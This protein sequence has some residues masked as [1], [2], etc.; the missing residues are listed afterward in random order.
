[1]I[2]SVTTT[3][4]VSSSA[5][6]TLQGRWEEQISHWSTSGLSKA[7]YCKSTGVDYHQMIYWSRK[8]TNKNGAQAKKRDTPSA[9]SKSGGF[10]AVSVT[11]VAAEL[12]IRLPNGIEIGGI[13]EQRLIQVI[14]LVSR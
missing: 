10:V 2:D 8:L 9:S 5:P 7:A 12:F 4:S 14:D 3:D 1:M 6:S 11:P 13:Q